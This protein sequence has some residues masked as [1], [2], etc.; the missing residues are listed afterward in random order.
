MQVS[1]HLPNGKAL[2]KRIR[3]V[4]DTRVDRTMFTN[5]STGGQISVAAYFR[6]T[7][8]VDISAPGMRPVNVGMQRNKPVWYPMDLCR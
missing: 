3:D 8:G 4:G 2:G 1:I 7:Y 6:D 5:D